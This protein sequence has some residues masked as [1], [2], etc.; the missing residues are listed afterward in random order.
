M[1]IK[2]SM[3]TT[4][5]KE[6]TENKNYSLLRWK[7]NTKFNPLDVKS[8]IH[9]CKKELFVTN[10]QKKSLLQPFHSM[11]FRLFFVVWLHDITVCAASCRQKLLHLTEI[12]GNMKIVLCLFKENLQLLFSSCSAGDSYGT[13]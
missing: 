4:L 5:K 9:L 10:Q 2:L 13:R 11:L 1:E 6:A 7:E 3:K 12:T 8:D